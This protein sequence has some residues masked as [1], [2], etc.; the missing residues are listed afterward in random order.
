MLIIHPVWLPFPVFLE[1]FTMRRSARETQ[2][3]D[4]FSMGACLCEAGREPALSF[5]NPFV[6]LM[7]TFII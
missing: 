1:S 5:Q 7:T 2:V 4:V 6:F 3:E